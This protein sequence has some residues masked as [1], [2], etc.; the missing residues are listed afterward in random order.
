[1]RLCLLLFMISFALSAVGCGMSSVTSA[2]AFPPASG[3]PLESD[4]EPTHTA[5]A[6]PTQSPTQLPTTVPTATA[7]PTPT[8]IPIPISDPV[9]IIIE[10]IA[11][12]Q[13]LVSVGL[14]E[15]RAP[16]VPNHNVGWYNLSARPGQGENVVLWGH[17]LRFRHAPDIPAPFVRLKEAPIGAKIA[18]HT[19]DGTTHHYEITE[20][21]P[22]TPDQ[23]AYILPQGDER[24]TLVSCIGDKVVVDN[25]VEMTHRLITIAKP[26]S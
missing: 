9:R 21:V 19:A 4:P 1:M 14:D 18:V 23:V 20:Q 6:S 2:E 7:E 11:L 25:T 10:D 13:P 24:L 12:D 3:R 22:V 17:V 26:T 15:N 8:A 16:V 5:K